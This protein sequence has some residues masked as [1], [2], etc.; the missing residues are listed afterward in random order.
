VFGSN[1]N[2]GFQHVAGI[3]LGATYR[4]KLNDTSRVTAAFMGTWLQYQKN[5]AAPGQASY[6]CAG[7]YGPTCGVPAPTW[8]HSLR[9]SWET[10]W[11]AMLSVNWRYIG[12]TGLDANTDNRILAAAGGGKYNIADS[13]LP[14]FNYFDLA[15]NVT[16][17]E[18]VT[19]RF[20]INNL[21]DKDPP[22]LDNYNFPIITAVGNGNTYS[23]LY[24]T[25]GRVAFV[26]LSVAY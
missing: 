18:H 1:Q 19:L 22:I 4:L 6:D 13:H 15:A 17:Q 9:V 21:F 2:T 3:D 24:S 26:G 20:G 7:L 5:Q 12:K 11:S 8:R 16:L 14:V 10:P 25:L 23:G